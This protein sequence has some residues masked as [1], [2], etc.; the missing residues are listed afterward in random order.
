[1]GDY[2]RKTTSTGEK[3]TKGQGGGERAKMAGMW[4]Q[5]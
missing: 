2:T 4:S 1:M 3:K 5:G